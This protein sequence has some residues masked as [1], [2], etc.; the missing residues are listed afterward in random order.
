MLLLLTDVHWAADVTHISGP[1]P[2]GWAPQLKD[3]LETVP[4][5]E[6]DLDEHALDT[7][8]QNCART[9]ADHFTIVLQ[10]NPLS[11][12]TEALK[13][14]AEVARL[15]EAFSSGSP[16]RANPSFRLL[17]QDCSISADRI[18]SVDFRFL[19]ESAAN[20]I[21][22]AMVGLSKH[23]LKESP[24]PDAP[25]EEKSWF[26]DWTVWTADE[27]T[28]LVREDLK[29]VIQ[30]DRFQIYAKVLDRVLST[31][32]KEFARV[33]YNHA[34]TSHA[35]DGTLKADKLV[36]PDP[37][38]GMPENGIYWGKK[39][40]KSSLGNA[41]GGLYRFYQQGAQCEENSTYSSAADAS[42][43]LKDFYNARRADSEAAKA[44]DQAD[45]VKEFTERMQQVAQSILLIALH[46]VHAG[47]SVQILNTYIDV[48]QRASHHIV[49]LDTELSK[50]ETHMRSVVEAIAS[51][52]DL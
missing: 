44:L 14:T 42:F 41:L 7:S 26:S 48:I 47:T 11:A 12:G 20:Q 10:E 5:V 16:A 46:G 28:H 33:L 45:L 51:A 25:N 9:F 4:P 27:E 18:S 52:M 37:P 32:T 39:K 1:F 34:A 13:T 36:C 43:T 31:P 40:N 38:H 22:A 17:K 3:P 35:S 23:A 19:P 24:A 30:V 50:S 29:E 15:V 49:Y 21:I 2:I 6:L 8:T